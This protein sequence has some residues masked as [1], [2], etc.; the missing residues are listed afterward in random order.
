MVKEKFQSS[1]FLIGQ[2]P[3]KKLWI[4]NSVFSIQHIDNRKRCY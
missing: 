3:I 1:V 4:E 2:V